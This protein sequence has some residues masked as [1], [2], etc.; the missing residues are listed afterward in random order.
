MQIKLKT[1][2]AVDL[3]EDEVKEILHEYKAW[4][5]DYFDSDKLVHYFEEMHKKAHMN[6][7]MI[8]D[9]TIETEKDMK[10]SL[11]RVMKYGS[12]SDVSD[13]II[14]AIECKVSYMIL[15]SMK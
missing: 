8:A 11:T 4:S 14:E 2:K 6:L 13:F 7:E 5:E 1:G 10:D 3:T 15:E 12:T 9:E